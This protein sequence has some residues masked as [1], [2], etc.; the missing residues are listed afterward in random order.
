MHNG[1]DSASACRSVGQ[2]ALLASFPKSG[3]TWT[4]LFLSAAYGAMEGRENFLLNRRPYTVPFASDRKF[5]LDET[6]LDTTEL[7]VGEATSAQAWALRELSASS[8]QTGARSAIKTH[9]RWLRGVGGEDVF[10]P[11]SCAKVVFL[12]RN[13]LDI[14]GSMAH[15]LGIS[16]DAAIANLIDPEFRMVPGLDERVHAQVPYVQG[17]WSSHTRSW[18]DAPHPDKL[19]VRYED[20]L[21]D[22][23]H[24]FSQIAKAFG[25]ELTRKQFEKAVEDTRFAK[26][27]KQENETGF[28]ERPIGL[29]QFFRQGK[30]GGWKTELSTA[31]IDRISH[32]F[33]D[34][35][36]RLNYATSS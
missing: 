6:G 14:V 26:L 4:R 9:D 25:L 17:S 30:S 19:V 27:Q 13:P 35:M 28:I 11:E 20:L 24:W 36:E 18:L 1:T 31:Q 7:T 3:N 34:I 8:A 23:E 12:V 22:P 29:S 10:G 2:L 5:I 32:A 33:A 21:A 16:L 15:H